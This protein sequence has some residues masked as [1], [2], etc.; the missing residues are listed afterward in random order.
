VTFIPDNDREERAV[1][2]EG[3]RG[4]ERGTEI[5]TQYVIN[6]RGPGAVRL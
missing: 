2:E 6:F 3:R 4:E 1:A 5:P